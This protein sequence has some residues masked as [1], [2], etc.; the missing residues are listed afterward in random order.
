MICIQVNDRRSAHS[1]HRIEVEMPD[2]VVVTNSPL[3]SGHSRPVSPRKDT[4]IFRES[5]ERHSEKGSVRDSGI[6][7]TAAMAND[8]Q[9][10]IL[11][12]RGL[13]SLSGS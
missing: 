3:D 7:T 9:H 5:R 6:D 12:D 13:A 2:R 10:L 11:V 4:A 8:K 1:H